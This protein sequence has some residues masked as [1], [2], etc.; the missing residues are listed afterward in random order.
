MPTTR[1]GGTGW[2]KPDAPGYDRTDRG[3][4]FHGRAESYPGIHQ[5]KDAPK[6]GW[7][8]RR[9]TVPAD[10]PA[11]QRVWLRFDAVDWRAEVWVNG[12]KIAEHEGG[13]TPFEADI[14]DALTPA[15]ENVLVVRAFDPTDPNLPTGKQVGWY[16]PSSG[17]WQTVWLEARAKSYIAD[18][19]WSRPFSRLRSKF[20]V[21]VA[22]FD[23]AT[24]QLGL[25]KNQPSVDQG[26]VTFEPGS[27]AAGE[28][29]WRQA[30]DPGSHC[31]IQGPPN[32]SSGP[33][34]IP[35]FTT[36]PSST[37][38]APQKYS[39]PSKLISACAASAAASM[40]TSR[41]SESS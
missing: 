20:T 27:S 12:R 28:P 21:D 17:I 9:F 22:G 24:Y 29:A 14:S 37:K 18:F 6:V 13:Y 33:R 19:T 11:E 1:G 16:T 2:E 34:K 31:R 4:D 3:P 5:V 25:G 38:T 30:D 10:F 26:L 7:Y 39:T 40:A 36:C 35:I 41:S 23:K 32:P 15:A 8:R